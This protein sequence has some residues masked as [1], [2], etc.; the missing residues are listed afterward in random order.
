MLRVK[1]AELDVARAVVAQLAAVIP[2]RPPDQAEQGARTRVAARR[3]LPRRRLVADAEVQAPLPIQL[4]EV[5]DLRG[6]GVFVG[7]PQR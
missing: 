5:I 3:T 6:G 1:E 4:V 7:R 2:V